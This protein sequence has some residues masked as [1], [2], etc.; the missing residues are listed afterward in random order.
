MSFSLDVNVLLYASDRKSDVHHEAMK[1]LNAVVEGEET[2]Y[3]AWITVMSYLRMATHPRIFD[4]PLSALEAQENISQL[5][6]RPHV[7]CIAEKE[8]FWPVYT[9]TASET[10]VRG[11][12]VPD[13]H[14]AAILK[15]HG[16][17]TLYTRDKDYRKFSFLRVIDPF[18]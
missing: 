2:C 16:I 11:N 15:Q 1:F 18:V 12:L 10:P 17:K 5:I 7:L 6:S 3:L 13:A 8:E 4:A 14:L 9:D